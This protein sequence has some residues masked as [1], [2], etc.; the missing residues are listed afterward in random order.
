MFQNLKGSKIYGRNLSSTP[1]K[2]S[3]PSLQADVLSRFML[4]QAT[5]TVFPLPPSTHV[6]A[7]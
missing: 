4:A 6:S 5:H 1:S 7:L 3:V 2:N